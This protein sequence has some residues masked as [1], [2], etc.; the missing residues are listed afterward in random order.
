MSEIRKS[1]EHR[2]SG[3]FVWPNETS[4]ARWAPIPLRLIVGFGFMQHGFAKFS[5]ALKLSPQS[6][7]QSGYLP[8]ISWPGLPF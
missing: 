5:K 1:L 2:G 6:C 3:R 7:M 4:A 8:L